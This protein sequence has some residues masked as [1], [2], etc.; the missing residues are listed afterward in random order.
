MT[1]S[2]LANR[3]AVAT[4]AASGIGFTV[5]KALAEACAKVVLPDV[6]EEAGRQSAAALHDCGLD[7]RSFSA[8]ASRE[9]DILQLLQLLLPGFGHDVRSGVLMTSVT[10]RPTTSWTSKKFL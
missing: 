1:E 9:D 2:S 7:V 3:V 6:R 4:G 10:C 5:A 8:D